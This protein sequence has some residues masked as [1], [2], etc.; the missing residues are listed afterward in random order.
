MRRTSTTWTA[1][2]LTALCGCATLQNMNLDDV[3]AGAGG[4]LDETTV[5]AGIKEALRIGAERTVGSV[6]AVDGF[7]GNE[8]IRIAAPSQLNSMTET[9]RDVGLGVVVDDLEEGMNRAAEAAAGEAL[10]VLWEAV[11]TMTVADAF[12]I[13]D[14]DQTAATDYFRDRTDTA[15]RARFQPIVH[16]AMNEVGVARLHDRLVTMYTNLPLS[17]APTAVSLEDYVTD[18]TLNGLFTVLA[19]EETQIRQDPVAR[20]TELLRRVFGE[21]TTR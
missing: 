21:R 2:A 20:T 13:L 8:M 10:S 14:G 15:L 7:L 6:S 5:T 11:R 12:G 4:G 9:L 16:N 17:G 19:G 1:L 3:L 18:R